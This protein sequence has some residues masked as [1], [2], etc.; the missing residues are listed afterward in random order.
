MTRGFEDE[1]TKIEGQGKGVT[2]RH[3]FCGVAQPEGRRAFEMSARLSGIA[4]LG[5]RLP[6]HAQV[7][8]IRIDL[9]I[10]RKADG[11]IRQSQGSAER[12]TK[13]MFQFGKRTG[14]S[15]YLRLGTRDI[16]LR[17]MGALAMTDPFGGV[18]LIIMTI[19]GH[20]IAVR[21]EWDP[22]LIIAAL[23]ASE[24]EIISLGVADAN[25]AQRV[26]IFMYVFKDL[27]K[28]FTGIPEEFTDLERGETL[29]QIL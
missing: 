9:G 18:T 13:G 1:T 14:G 15:G 7:P 25:G 11:T 16:G 29:A 5:V 28:T 22:V 17:L 4:A 6:A 10:A 12:K 3:R 26:E 20:A 27:I 19:A 24:R 2:D 21:T 8:D 23:E